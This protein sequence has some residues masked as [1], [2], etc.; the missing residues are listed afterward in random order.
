M[1]TSTKTEEFIRQLTEN[2]VPVRPLAPAYRR[3]AAW[4]ALSI[5][6]V[7][8]VM[9]IVVAVTGRTLFSNLADPA[10]ILE[11]SAA[12]VTGVAAAVAAFALTIPGRS[13]KWM[14]LPL[15]SL[16]IWLAS[17][18][19]GC[20]QEWNRFGW[21]SLP[22][23]HNL[24]CFPFII[25]F[26]AVPSLVMWRMLRRGAPLAPHMTAALGGLAAAG[27]ANVGVRLVHPEDVTVM[28][29]VWHMGGVI[30]LSAV[31]AG[32]GRYLLNWRSIISSSENTAR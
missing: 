16:G 11:E 19:P 27:L 14:L 20:I 4:L 2:A 28:L 26:G 18:G 7:V 6:Y 8:V 29:L 21:Q 9:L 13:P 3:A 32:A 12:L 30:V 15:P 1:S 10:F 5:G 22:L 24:L 25:I 17:L 23:T 31:A